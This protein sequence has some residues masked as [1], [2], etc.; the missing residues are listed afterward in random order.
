MRQKDEKQK[1]SKL[2]SAQEEQRTQVMVM[3]STQTT[4]TVYWNHIEHNVT[5]YSSMFKT[6]CQKKN[7]H[8]VTNYQVKR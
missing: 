7:K 8:H 5:H 3:T 4:N 6:K 1:L 2:V